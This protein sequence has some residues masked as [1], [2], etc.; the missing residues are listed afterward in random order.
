MEKKEV[1]FLRNDNDIERLR[2]IYLKKLSKPKL[3]SERARIITKAY[4]ETEGEPMT[5]RRAKALR[6]ILSEMTIYIQQWD[7]IVGNLGPEPVSVPVYPEGAVDFILNQL[8][9][10]NT[11]E[12][13]KF[14]VTEDVKK[15]LRE[16]LSWWKGKTLKE[17]ALSITPEEVKEA[18]DAGL[19][20]YENMLT[21]G[22]GHFVPS[23]EKILHWG[24]EGIEKTI[25]DKISSLN[26]ED[27]ED[28]QKNIFYKACLIVCDGVKIYAKRY[29]NKAR[30][31]AEKC[32]DTQR[33][34]ELLQMAE[35]CEHVPAKPAR[36][37]WEALQAVWFTHVICYIDSNGYAVTLG[38]MDQYLYPY[39]KRD[40]KEGRFTRE[41]A[42]RLLISFW[43]KCSD[44]LKLYSNAAAQVYAGFPVSQCPELGGLTPLGEDATNE[45]SELILEVEEKVRLPQ[46]DI[47]VLWSNKM[48]DTFLI[49]AAK[50]VRKN[51]K[52]KFFNKHIGI[53]ALINAGVPMEEA[54]KDWVF[55]G[56]VEN[57]VAGKTW[58]W[59]NAG[60]YNI[61]K[62]LELVL[63]N[64]VD[65]MTGKQLGPATGD[66][67]KFKS[68]DKFIKAFKEQAAHTVKMLVK[69]VHAV[70]ITHREIWPEIWE[71]I[72][73]DDCLEKGVDVHHG[74]ARYNFSGI[75][76][77]GLATVV[78][79]LMAINKFK[80][81]KKEMEIKNILRALRN[82]FEGEEM[83]RQKL[84]NNTPKYGNDIEKV[85]QLACEIASF[86]CDE[87]QKYR[88]LRGGKFTAGFYTNAAQV[89]FGKFVGATPDGRK[90]KEPL[91]DACSPA[92]G[93]DKRGQ[94][95]VVRSVAKLPSEKAGNGMLLNMKF[96]IHTLNGEER[97]KK[98][99]MLIKTFMQLGGF[100]VQF[101]IIDPQVLIDA[102]KNPERYPNL[103]VRVAAYVALWNQLSKQTQDE[104]IERTLYLMGEVPKQ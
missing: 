45:L 44:I 95:A 28:F 60:Y 85:D 27:P 53:K 81:E 56:C 90:A 25:K 24:I 71:S 67:T 35:I 51:N 46:P 43:F 20:T 40:V 83:L 101:N 52:P 88:N 32:N 99:A 18:N 31:L 92:H 6:K 50:V 29:A 70:E 34:K 21:G 26:L 75:Q 86:L 7:L 73:V 39:Y 59:H 47:A 36:T 76:A 74:G 38:R 13:D 30:E 66:P 12:G 63:N 91:S 14:E 93:A 104:I 89:Y 69:G 87:V 82:N 3:T 9:T 15:E 96:N 57:S 2:E 22:I 19:F 23:Y 42:K 1:I 64:G 11:R 68:I 97:I 100:H 103:M 10:F 77:V 72:L 54:R 61:A 55:V 48:K 49:K 78:D 5:I 58:G 84:M 65:P 4:K 16:T 17:Y 79:S 98:F 80:F 102:Q 8:D 33:K 37:F 62:S 94:T 41:D